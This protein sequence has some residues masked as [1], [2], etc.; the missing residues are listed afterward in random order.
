MIGRLKYRFFALARRRWL[1]IAVASLVPI[2]MRLAVLAKH[3]VPL[4]SVAD[5]FSYL[6][7]ADT[8]ASGHLATSTHP[9]WKFFETL[10]II[11]TPSYMSKYQPVQGAVLALGQL[12]TGVPWAGVLV[13]G[14]LMCGA[15]C[16]MLQGWTRPVWA[17]SGALL[18]ATQL[19]TFSYWMD[20]YMGGFI[21]AIGGSL[22]LGALPRLGRIRGAAWALG[23]GFAILVNSR[24]FE[25]GVLGLAAA[26]WIA[27]NLPVRR[28][29]SLS[30]AA[31]V[32]LGCVAWI[33]FYNHAVTGNA[34]TLPYR[35]H[36]MR[37]AV[38]S[39]FLYFEP[40]RAVPA[41]N[42]EAL[43]AVWAG[44]DLERYDSERADLAGYYGRSA[45]AM[46]K[47]FLGDGLLLILFPIGLYAAYTRRR[48]RRAIP[49]LLVFAAGLCLVK[50]MLPHYAAPVT[51]LIFLF[52]ALALSQLDRWSAGIPASALVLLAAFGAYIA[53][54]GI[55]LAAPKGAFQASPAHDYGAHRQAIQDRLEK[56]AGKQLVVVRYGLE[57][58]P[59][60]EYV[61]NR[62][63]ID[64]ANV[65]WARSMTEGENRELVRYF[66]DR[67]VWRLTV[68]ADSAE[69]RLEPMPS[70]I[71]SRG[72]PAP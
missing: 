67:R 66:K 69:P 7:A 31:A 53:Q 1:A 65:V 36:E 34:F 27:W 13:T 54:A 49:L 61:Y 64:G 44:Q 29:S 62:A 52:L 24:P 19:A 32:G 33:G 10:H 57:H 12:L 71:A 22:V 2:L 58:N 42:H 72:T 70:E 18:A 4:P 68:S 28:W 16:W 45:Q 23:A 20:G 6:L 60:Y 15:I 3:P 39:P 48:H 35:V 41:Y 26:L 47:I 40:P 30:P 55:I 8:Y 14:G 43:K 56:E 51:G 11:H 46:A 25:G 38:A 9:M 17:L 21:P 63:N 5:E 37:Y 50:T 59:E